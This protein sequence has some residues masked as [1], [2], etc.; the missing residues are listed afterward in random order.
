MTRALAALVL[1]LVALVLAGC[2]DDDSGTASKGPSGTMIMAT[3][4]ITT[5]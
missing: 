2:G 1:A 5:A 3:T 4:I